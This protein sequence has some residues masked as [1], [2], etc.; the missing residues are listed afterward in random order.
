MSRGSASL[1]GGWT[2][3]AAAFQ[4]YGDT[5]TCRLTG[6]T[7]HYTGGCIPSRIGV[8]GSN[9]EPTH[10]CTPHPRLSTIPSHRMGWRVQSTRRLT[11]ELPA[12]RTEEEPGSGT[13]DYSRVL[14]YI[15]PEAALR[16]VIS[17]GF[18]SWRLIICRSPTCVITPQPITQPYL[19]ENVAGR[20]SGRQRWC[21]SSILNVGLQKALLHK[22]VNYW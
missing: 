17:I 2:R 14:G 13:W 7:L 6:V 21:H 9:V 11:C 20:E 18:I 16:G 3:Q 12:L 15:H 4:D 10:H 1:P 8:S 22:V 19:A 5:T